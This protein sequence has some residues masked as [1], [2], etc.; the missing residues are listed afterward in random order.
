MASTVPI[1]FSEDS[2]TCSQQCPGQH[3]AQNVRK[4]IR[5][6]QFATLA[7]A[8]TK[9]LVLGAL[10]DAY[11]LLLGGKN[12]FVGNVESAN[13]IFMLL[14]AFPVGYLADRFEKVDVLRLNGAVGVLGALL[15]VAG[16]TRDVA[17]AVVAGSIMLS[18]HSQNYLTVA[19]TLIADLTSEGEERSK[20]IRD[21]AS[22]GDMG[23]AAGPAFQLAIILIQG[24]RDKQ[25]SDTWTV[26]ELHPIILCGL[27][28]FFPYLFSLSLLTRG[29]SSQV[30]LLQ[31]PQNETSA[32]PVACSNTSTWKRWFAASLLEIGGLLTSIGS[33]MTF[34]F[35]PLFFK[36]DYRFSPAAVCAF[37]CIS[38]ASIA[39]GAKLST[40]VSKYCGSRIRSSILAHYVGTALL[41][42]ISFGGPAVYILPLVVLRNA[43]TNSY[44][45]T[46]QS[47]LM[48]LVPREHR[49]KWSGIASL[50]R[51][52]WSAS[53]F[54][55]GWLSDAH[56]YR[57]AFF[58]TACFHSLSGLFLVFLIPLQL[59]L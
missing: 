31:D 29:V 15:L 38:W 23:N 47:M 8:T 43:V 39:V 17:Q 40:K 34:K 14:F 7:D 56:D 44:V 9:A 10:F 58:I 2:F 49:G 50:R 53:A 28:L 33:G 19:S 11:L 16:V 59:K 36:G 45:P 13:G 54:L 32:S 4:N 5:R 48:D 26:K 20:V 1:Q 46:V 27:V 12:E 18:V 3:C 52:S 21:N 22:L 35:W 25:K 57:Y 6:I 42:V 41:F 55:G 37:Q 24:A 30:Q 51:L